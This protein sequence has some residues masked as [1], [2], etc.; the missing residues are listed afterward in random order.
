M[1][2]C[3]TSARHLLNAPTTVQLHLAVIRID[4]II[5]G[6]PF[7]VARKCCPSPCLLVSGP[8]GFDSY[9]VCVAPLLYM[10]HDIVNDYTQTTPMISRPKLQLGRRRGLCVIYYLFGN[11]NCRAGHDVMSQPTRSRC[12]GVLGFIEY[13]FIHSQ[14]VT[15]ISIRKLASCG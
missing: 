14:R 4:W 11:L 10:G 13:L 6:V 12:N 9:N 8:L 5:L 2:R 15:R 3:R 7:H 1:L